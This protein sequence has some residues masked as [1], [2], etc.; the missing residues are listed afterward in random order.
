MWEYGLILLSTVI[1]NL[2][3]RQFCFRRI[4]FKR[5]PAYVNAFQRTLERDEMNAVKRAIKEKRHEIL[6]QKQVV[7]KSEEDMDEL[8]KN[9]D[10]RYDD[11]GDRQGPENWEIWK[12][13]FSHKM[14]FFATDS[15]GM[16]SWK[17]WKLKA[18][19]VISFILLIFL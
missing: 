12:Q 14:S 18:I 15:V 3:L 9:V 16:T 8:V 6:E 5:F 19:S 11:I 17:Q 7:M 2:F 4:T 10:F 1:L 13:H